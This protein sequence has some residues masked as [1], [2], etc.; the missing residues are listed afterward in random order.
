MVGREIGRK[1]KLIGQ[2]IVKSFFF[3]DEIV[4]IDV[5]SPVLVYDLISDEVRDDRKF[6][7]GTFLIKG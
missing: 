4:R 5:K 7:I 3:Q 1:N 6:I 2:E